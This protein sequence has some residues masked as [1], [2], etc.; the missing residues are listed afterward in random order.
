MN[1][2]VTIDSRAADV[3]ST[4]ITNMSGTNWFL[5]E[6]I[7]GYL[8]APFDF[9][10]EI[11]FDEAEMTFVYD[12]SV[13]TD[14]FRPEIFYYNEAEQ[15]LERLENQTHDPES[16][17]VT[18][19]VEHFSVYLLLN[20]VI[21]DAV[22]EN[23]IRPFD[24]A[25]D[26]EKGNTDVAFAIDSSSSM[27]SN[28]PNDLRKKASKAFTDKLKEGDRAAVVDFD[29]YA[30]LHSGLI[31]DKVAVKAAIDLVDQS[32]G[33]NLF[34]GIMMALEEL[35][36]N[37]SVDHSK[38]VVFLTDGQGSWDDL[39]IDYANEHQIKIFTIGLGSGVDQHLL[40]RIASSTGGKYYHADEA[41]SLEG[42]FDESAEDIIGYPSDRDCDGVPDQLE[43]N[44]VRLG[45]GTT[46]FTD[47]TI[48]DT[49]GDGLLD[50]EE[51]TLEFVDY[52]GGYYISYSDPTLK[53][54]D[55]DG[56]ID[57]EEIKENRMVYNVSNRTL[58]HISNLAYVNLESHL[59]KKIGDASSIGN[60][61][62][63]D[64]LKDE[65]ADWTIIKANDGGFTSGGFGGVAV[66]KGH[67]IIIGYR[68]TAFGLTPE[69]IY[70]VIA[71][72]DIYVSGNNFQGSLATSFASEIVSSYPKANAY[73]TGHSLGG[74]LAQIVS[75]RMLDYHLHKSYLPLSSNRAVVKAALAD[76]SYLKKTVTF[77][78]APFFRP[79]YFHK[80]GLGM[81][82]S[83]V[84]IWDLASQKFDHKVYNY[85][86]DGDFLQL[87]VD[88]HV[89]DKLGQVV[90]AYPKKRDGN[91]HSLV[92]FY[93]HFPKL[94]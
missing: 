38:F 75:Y 94:D 82:T 24:E 27:S 23:E 66:K 41:N 93:D 87:A 19:T 36:D 61:N 39:A 14:E 84:P 89:A 71:D 92:Q 78:A 20:G 6:D 72:I 18:A 35:V 16:H 67:D 5:S 77:N 8:G 54:T 90:P 47:F 28:D 64:E 88:I 2:Q 13:V 33:T 49:D 81:I 55:K 57:S 68:G 3:T 69:T 59:F 50:G 74:F 51:V 25:T 52:N 1:P 22:W 26:A 7:P 32:G 45:N 73:V 21:W 17:S 60:H 86:I 58:T 46:V 44:G 11:D 31:T 70:D 4:T 56:I 76:G 65:I 91:A 79:T 12:E 30:T 62:H 83:A 15:R 40:E 85:S 63:F 37:D 53:D 43:K 34:S 42:I 80:K 48:A 9:N 29:N 10:T